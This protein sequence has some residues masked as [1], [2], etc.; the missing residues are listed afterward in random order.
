VE[1]VITSDTF[2]AALFSP[3]PVCL[4]VSKKKL[5]GGFSRNLGKWKTIHQRTESDPEHIPDISTV[6]I[7]NPIIC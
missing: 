3:T 6:F 1:I 2:G 4:L 7:G 5:L